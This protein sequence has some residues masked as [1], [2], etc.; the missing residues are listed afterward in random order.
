MART[1][2]ANA[3]TDTA[4]TQRGPFT[5]SVTNTA[6]GYTAHDHKRTTVYEGVGTDVGHENE[7][8][9]PPPHSP[10]GWARGRDYY[11]NGGGVG[12]SFLDNQ[13]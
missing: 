2:R 5:Q 4:L 10:V 6:V 11:A 8:V 9:T 3:Y 1:A 12:Q 13:A 7:G